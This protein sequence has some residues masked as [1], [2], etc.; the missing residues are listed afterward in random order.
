MTAKQ[1]AILLAI[2][3]AI[4]LYYN[5][6]C[7]IDGRPIANEVAP[8]TFDPDSLKIIPDPTQLSMCIVDAG[9][10]IKC[11]ADSLGML[12]GS[13]KIEKIYS[14]M[15]D[16]SINCLSYYFVYSPS[17]ASGKAGYLKLVFHGNYYDEANRKINKLTGPYY[18]S[19]MECPINCP[20]RD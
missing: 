2:L 8:V 4:S 1:F 17:D 19:D 16:S 14:M 3:L 6:E 12:G 15:G 18:S 11:S 10:I 5:I 20:Q 13:V 7:Y 9:G